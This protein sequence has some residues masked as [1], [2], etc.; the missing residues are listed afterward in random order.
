MSDSIPATVGDVIAAF[1]ES[2]GV[3]LAFGVVSV[4]NI[5]ILDAINRRQRIRFVPAR[6]EA[7]ATN[8]ADAA[9][10]VSGSLGVVI[11]STGTGAGNAAGALVE[12]RTAGTPLLHLT[13]QIESAYLDRDA[14]YI[15]EAPDQLGMLRAISKAA[16]RVRSAETA[17]GTVREAIRM[18]CTAPQ[19]PVSVEIP[20]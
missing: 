10:R 1:L 5:P 13:G 8:M 11:T 16:Y 2:L 4:H 18:A 17:L 20:I 9:A 7:G 12:A 19:G 3:E 6:G 14:G 15:H